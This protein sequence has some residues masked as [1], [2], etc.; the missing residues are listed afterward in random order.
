MWCELIK[1]VCNKSPSVILNDSE[2]EN[3]VVIDSIDFSDRNFMVISFGSVVIFL[4]VWLL[5]RITYEFNDCNGIAI[6]S[7]RYFSV[8]INKYHVIINLLSFFLTKKSQQILLIS[9]IDGIK[10]HCDK[11]YRKCRNKNCTCTNGWFRGLFPIY[12]FCYGIM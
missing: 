4:F 5:N 10:N 3:N 1:N 7:Y 9:Y 2:G 11:M 12:R 8:K 6:F